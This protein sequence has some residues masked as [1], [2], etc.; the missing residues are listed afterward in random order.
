MPA[1]LLL[2]GKGAETVEQRAKIDIHRP[3]IRVARFARQ[4]PCTFD[5]IS[6]LANLSAFKVASSTEGQRPSGKHP[7]GGIFVADDLAILVA[8]VA[9]NTDETVANRCLITF[10]QLKA[11]SVLLNQKPGDIVSA[12]TFP[13]CREKVIERIIAQ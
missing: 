5:D 9:A 7:S 10:D 11:K 2:H 8:P 4:A 12:I 1:G 3:A 13:R 6:Q